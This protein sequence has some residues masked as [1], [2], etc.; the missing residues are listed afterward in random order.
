MKEKKKCFG[1][2]MLASYHYRYPVITRTACRY[3]VMLSVFLCA[4]VV[5]YLLTPCVLLDF[6]SSMDLC[7]KSTRAQNL[8]FPEP[9][10]ASIFEHF[11]DPHCRRS[12]K[13]T[14]PSLSD[15]FGAAAPCPAPCSNRCR[16]SASCSSCW[17]PSSTSTAG[18]SYTGTSRCPTCS[19][20][21]RSAPCRCSSRAVFSVLSSKRF[22]I[23]GDKC[24]CC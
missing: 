1:E 22:H 9:A 11:R 20:T 8:T 18:G 10:P 3:F 19:T 15:C 5:L 21:T 12:Y 2:K 14:F 24:N 7:H 16:S 13:N 23:D 6:C 17:R 4:C